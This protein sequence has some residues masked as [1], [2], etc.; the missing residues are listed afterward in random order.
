MEYPKFKRGF[1]F[2]HIWHIV[3]DFEKFKD[4][5]PTVRQNANYESSH[6]GNP[7]LESPISVSPR[8][9]SFSPN[10]DDNGFDGTSS[11]RPTRVKK[12]KLKRKK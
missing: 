4:N 6:S 10:L 11:Q 3:K 9:S 5:I 2:D 7:T 8:L 12:A 1:K